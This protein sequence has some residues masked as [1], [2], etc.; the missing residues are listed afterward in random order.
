MEL[1]KKRLE[2]MKATFPE[3]MEKMRSVQSLAMFYMTLESEGKKPVYY[4][5]TVGPDDANKVLMRWK[6][7]DGL[8]RVVFGDLLTSDVTVEELEVLE[9]Q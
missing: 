5:Q 4:G 1:R 9:N 3:S 8:Y 2:D 7:S 6:V